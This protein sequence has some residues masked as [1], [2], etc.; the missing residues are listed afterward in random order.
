MS[1]KKLILFAIVFIIAQIELSAA[2][3][4]LR[5]EKLLH[6]SPRIYENYPCGLRLG[7][8]SFGPEMRPFW[9]ALGW[10]KLLWDMWG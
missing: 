1:L 5:F 6:S 10:Y 4:G 7:Q 8:K 3:G 9:Q 2:Y